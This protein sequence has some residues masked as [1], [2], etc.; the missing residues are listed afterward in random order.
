MLRETRREG[1]HS[2]IVSVKSRRQ[3]RWGSRGGMSEQ[4]QGPDRK[5]ATVCRILGLVPGHLSLV[6]LSSRYAER[7]KV[8]VGSLLI[9]EWKMEVSG[10]DCFSQIVVN[11]AD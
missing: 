5:G 7:K 3:R 6:A 4:C 9:V 11:I 8:V 10:I 1:M 2:E